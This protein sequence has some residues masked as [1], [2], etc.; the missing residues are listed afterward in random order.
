MATHKLKILPKYYE[1]VLTGEKTFELRKNDRNYKVGD[2][3]I[4]EEHHLYSSSGR[5][6][7]CRITY[8]LKDCSEYGLKDGFVI[9]G[10]K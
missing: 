2:K 7:L 5:A 8:I 1:K 4:L 3:L 6:Y 9:L 10:I